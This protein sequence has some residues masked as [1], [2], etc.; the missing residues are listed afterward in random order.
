[1]KDTMKHDAEIKNL[2][3]GI[4][5]KNSDAH[6]EFYER[7]YRMAYSTALKMVHNK[8]DAD[9]ILQDAYLTFYT[10]ID[11]L[12]TPETAFAWFKSIVN[13][14]CK[15]A[16]KKKKPMLF[17]EI[18][19]DE[20]SFVDMLEEKDE[21][22]QPEASADYSETKRIMDGFID[23]LPEDQ[24]LCVLM[25]YYQDS[26]VK[27][28][29]ETLDCS[30]NTI[31]GRLSYARKRIENAVLALE[32]QG[33][34]L[35]GVAPMP[36]IGW[37]LRE[38]EALHTVSDTLYANIISEIG[39]GATATAGV[40]SSSV[41]ASKATAVAAVA[42][43]AIA[44]K[45]VAGIVAASLAVGGIVVAYN[46]THQDDAPESGEE[47]TAVQE[48]TQEE[49]F[50]EIDMAYLE[51]LLYYLPLYSEDD[52]ITDE[53][54]RTLIQQSMLF[55]GL[56]D[57]NDFAYSGVLDNV[58]GIERG[59]NTRMG[60]ESRYIAAP[61]SAF[62]EVAKLVG[63]SGEINAGFIDGEYPSDMFYLENDYIYVMLSGLGGFVYTWD[64]EIAGEQKE[65]NTM[66]VDY[67]LT[68]T[69]LPDNEVKVSN[70]RA[71]IESTADGHIIHSIVE[72]EGSTGGTSI[73]EY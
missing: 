63:F 36:F 27:E 8:E 9:D 49:T 43:K 2:V 61:V 58:D 62:E 66:V 65:G 72:T 11:T 16:V 34:K 10:K 40:G 42:T 5:N 25:Y 69:F 53:E 31:K 54:F 15:D 19:T 22:F 59:T 26:S 7:S 51:K 29:A 56:G 35:Y 20:M 12:Q 48:E 60:F 14:K 6:R 50:A 1:M 39:A 23:Q 33:T 38:G 73:V 18:D 67:I 68:T 32:K 4:K 44:A 55:Q 47:P 71:T 70:R 64:V 45:V 46:H 52:P 24:R 57:N 37:M 17:N 13:N 3:E 41:T 21:E 30:E 28:I